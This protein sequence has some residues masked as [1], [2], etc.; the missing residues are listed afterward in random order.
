MKIKSIFWIV[1]AYILLIGCESNLNSECYSNNY[2]EITASNLSKIGEFYELQF[3]QDYIQ[4]FST[5]K[6][7]TGSVDAYQK[8][9]WIS[10]KE[11]FVNGYWTN[12]VNRSSYTDEKGEAY[13]VLGVWEEF[14]GDTVIVYCWYDDMCFDFIDS[15]K[16]IIR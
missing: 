14:I 4:T 7:E 16:V 15:L 13:T 5:I 9:S 8:L 12:L 10:N 2:L 6:A 11:I 1:F 3:L